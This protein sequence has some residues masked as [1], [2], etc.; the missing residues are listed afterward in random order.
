MAFGSNP[1]EALSLRYVEGRLRLELELSGT[2]TED[3]MVFAQAPCSPGWTKWR[4]GACL[5][6][7]PV[8]R[9]GVSDITQM[10]REAF[11]EPEPGRKV[12][13]RTRQQSNGWEDE[14][15][16]VSWCRLTPWQPRV[17]QASRLPIS[18]W[19]PH[20]ALQSPYCPAPARPPSPRPFACPAT[21]PCPDRAQGTATIP[22]PGCYRCSAAPAQAIQAAPARSRRCGGFVPSP[23]SAGP[24]IGVS[25]GTA[26]SGGSGGYPIRNQPILSS[27]RRRHGSRSEPPSR[28]PWVE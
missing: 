11:G 7:L 16:D 19:P 28:M 9:N 20:A 5:G 18:P 1:V 25:D 17:G 2:V 6:L 27:C 22:P 10:Y 23:D 4:H 26:V 24:A 12:F 21:T 15:K 8:P 3:I 14:A 13:I